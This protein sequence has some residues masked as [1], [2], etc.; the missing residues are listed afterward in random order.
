MNN[1]AGSSAHTVAMLLE[2]IH[3]TIK[4]GNQE[5]F[6]C[7]DRVS[8]SLIHLQIPANPSQLSFWTLRQRLLPKLPNPA[9]HAKQG[10][11]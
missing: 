7:A 9:I 11:K 1:S 3:Y 4:F 8:E 5:T 2:L 10:K 6:S